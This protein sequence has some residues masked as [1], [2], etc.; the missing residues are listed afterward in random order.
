MCQMEYTLVIIYQMEYTLVST[1]DG[2]HHSLVSEL[3]RMHPMEC[4]LVSAFDRVHQME[5]TQVRALNDVYIYIMHLA[6]I[7][8]Y[9]NML[10]RWS[11][12]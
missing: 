9:T 2:V 12:H 10:I 5:Y 8:V 11:V 1:L 3:D 7:L 4:T 6:N